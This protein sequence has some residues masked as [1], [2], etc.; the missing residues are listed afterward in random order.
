MKVKK[1]FKFQ[2]TKSIAISSSPKEIADLTQTDGNLV[3][4]V[5]IVYSCKILYDPWARKG[6]L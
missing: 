2:K 6:T 3:L 4:P 1:H 5:L